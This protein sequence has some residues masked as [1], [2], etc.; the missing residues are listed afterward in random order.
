MGLC[1]LRLQHAQSQRVRAAQCTVA[2]PREQWG[3]EGSSTQL[4]AEGRSVVPVCAVC[5]GPQQAGDARSVPVVRS[6]PGFVR[7]SIFWTS[8][9]V[10]Y[11]VLVASSVTPLARFACASV[12]SVLVPHAC[13]SAHHRSDRNARVSSRRLPENRGPASITATLQHGCGI[14]LLTGLSC[15][16]PVLQIAPIPE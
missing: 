11:G 10:V 6:A 1:K 12:A 15:P 5:T 13:C 2:V 8:L 4:R 16:S 14:L 7:I 9:R 3:R